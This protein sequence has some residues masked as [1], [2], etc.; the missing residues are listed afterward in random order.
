MNDE[1]DIRGDCDIDLLPSSSDDDDERLKS[2]SICGD[3]GEHVI[4]IGVCLGVVCDLGV[5]LVGNGLVGNDL[6]DGLCNGLRV[7]LFDDKFQ[8]VNDLFDGLFD[9]DDDDGAKYL[10]DDD[11]DD[12]DDDV[13]D[14]LDRFRRIS[15]KYFV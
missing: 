1:Y 10:Y 8:F 13:A 6:F 11:D 15:T 7:G 4:C 3:A 2:K 14:G 9:D 5:G 12:D